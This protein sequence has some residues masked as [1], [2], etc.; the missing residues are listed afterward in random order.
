MTG[1]FET[2]PDAPF[3]QS[4]KVPD[5]GRDRRR[6]LAFGYIRGPMTGVNAVPAVADELLGLLVKGRRQRREGGQS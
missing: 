4:A 3:V 1:R 6:R 2:G 5:P